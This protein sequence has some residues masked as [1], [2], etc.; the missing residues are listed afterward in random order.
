MAQIYFVLDGVMAIIRL[1]YA[2]DNNT[3][4]KHKTVI[5]TLLVSKHY[6]R[7]G[8]NWK[9]TNEVRQTTWSDQIYPDYLHLFLLISNFSKAVLRHQNQAKHPVINQL[10]LARSPTRKPLA[11]SIF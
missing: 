3:Y 7:E 4:Q 9:H 6:F 5:P 2:Y 1:N 8:Y 11:Q 10:R